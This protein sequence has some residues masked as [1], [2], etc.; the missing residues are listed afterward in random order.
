MVL[1][2]IIYI[3]IFLL[4]IGSIVVLG[5]SLALFIP[6]AIL[7]LFLFSLTMGGT[8]AVVYNWSEYQ[9]EVWRPFMKGVGRNFRHSVVFFLCLLVLLLLYF[10]V[11]PFY[12]S[13]NNMVGTIFGV[14]MVW[15]SVFLLLVLPYLPPFRCYRN[16]H[17]TR[18]G[19]GEK[20]Y[21][22]VTSMPVTSFVTIA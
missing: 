8:A 18:C 4:F 12:L 11:I 7:I 13:F 9:S 17:P 14:I 22:I 20:F 19:V 10:L 3:I 2:N 5:D 1:Q 16:P 15:L 6:A 21:I